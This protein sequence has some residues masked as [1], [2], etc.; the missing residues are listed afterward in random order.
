MPSEQ[1]LSGLTCLGLILICPGV[2]QQPP[3]NNEDPGLGTR[4]FRNVLAIDSEKEWIYRPSTTNPQHVA[5]H[6]LQALEAMGLTYG[7]PETP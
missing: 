5:M 2:Q 3:V 7:L 1:S 4:P 6:N